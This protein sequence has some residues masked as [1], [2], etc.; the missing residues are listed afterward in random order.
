VAN[1]PIILFINIP[2]DKFIIVDKSLTTNL[3]KSNSILIKYK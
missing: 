3:Y 2:P 1:N